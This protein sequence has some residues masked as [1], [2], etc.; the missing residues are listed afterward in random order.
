[1]STQLTLNGKAVE[2]VA[3][4]AG[5]VTY[6]SEDGVT[7]KARVSKF[8]GQTK[9]AA[10]KAK[11]KGKSAKS[12]GAVTGNIIRD[13]SG[14]KPY[15][16]EDGVKGL[17]N[18]DKIA[19]QLRGLDL[20]GVY[21]ETARAIRHAGTEEG[22]IEDI[23]SSLRKRYGKLNPGQQRMSLG[24]RLRGASRTQAAA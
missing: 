3:R 1:M 13:R 4:K 8:D 18:G 10:K 23:E 17:D 16:T 7:K 11:G 15:K 14:F 19:K 12:N 21:S 24:N 9:S 5:W 20:D 2:V 22:T 6:I